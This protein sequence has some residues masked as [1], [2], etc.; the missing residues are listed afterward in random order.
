MKNQLIAADDRLK[1]KKIKIQIYSESKVK[2]IH[3]IIK[4][5]SRQIH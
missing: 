2:Y 1:C 5:L 4:K 3:K